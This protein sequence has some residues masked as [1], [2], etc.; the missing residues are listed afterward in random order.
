MRVYVE[1]PRST[2]GWKGL[3]HDPDHAHTQH[4]NASLRVENRSGINKGLVVSR[5]IM[6]NVAK[7]GLPIATELLSPLLVNYFQDLV[8]IGVIG[9]RT[10]ESQTHRE[11]SSAM[12]MPVGFKNGTDGGLKAAIDAMMATSRSHSVV[13]V[14]EEGRLTCDVSRGN[15]DTF[16]ILRGGSQ[17]PNFG[18]EHVRDAE[19][20]LLHSGNN[21]CIV[22][23]CSHG[24]SMKDYRNQGAVAACVA[25]QIAA[26]AP[27][28]GVMLESNINEGKYNN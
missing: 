26:G 5:Q 27:I 14:D 8:T 20:Q 21:P 15:P 19:K 6:L 1:K 12:P 4:T 11:M 13:G 28:M 18:A 23:D 9:A 2:V 3:L 17:G 10:T 22:V 24:N 7:K 16:M 25:D